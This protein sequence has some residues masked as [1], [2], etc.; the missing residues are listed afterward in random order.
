MGEQPGGELEVASWGSQEAG[1]G[2]AEVAVAHVGT[3]WP[4][5]LSGVSVAQVSLETRDTSHPLPYRSQERA[6]DVRAAMV[7]FLNQKMVLKS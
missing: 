6:G 4:Q 3:Q 1:A 2:P 7:T 5:F